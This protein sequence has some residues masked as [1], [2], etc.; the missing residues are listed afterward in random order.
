MGST[1]DVPW[2]RT[3]R[4]FRDDSNQ[5]VKD[6]GISEQKLT[7]EQI[8]VLQSP[9]VRERCGSDYYSQR[10]GANFWKGKRHRRP[11]YRLDTRK[12]IRD[13][14]SDPR[15]GSVPAGRSG[16]QWRRAVGHDRLG[17]KVNGKGRGFT[18]ETRRVTICRGR[19]NGCCP[20]LPF[21]PP[22]ACSVLFRRRQRTD[23]FTVSHR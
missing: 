18:G 9:T 17:G 4:R 7:P 3:T 20:G 2:P 6:A 16:R 13:R 19:S 12:G 5:E 10:L 15:L 21:S 22:A 1:E 8:A 14:Q 23:S 11:V